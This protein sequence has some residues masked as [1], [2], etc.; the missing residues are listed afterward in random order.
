M[1]AWKPQFF[2]P[3]QFLPEAEFDKQVFVSS[4]VCAVVKSPP[5]IDVFLPRSI[6]THR[7]W[8]G[9][10]LADPPIGDSTSVRSAIT[11]RNDLSVIHRRSP[12]DS[13]D[14]RAGRH[15]DPP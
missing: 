12:A 5:A 8:E 6:D 1:E 13:S 9:L 4:A 2:I 3:R 10:H 7:W 15:D 11:A 14:K